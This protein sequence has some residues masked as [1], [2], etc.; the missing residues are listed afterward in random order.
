MAPDTEVCFHFPIR[1]LPS[2]LGLLCSVLCV[3]FSSTVPCFCCGIKVKKN[4]IQYFG[5]LH[6]LYIKYIITLLFL[7]S[8][9]QK[10]VMTSM[11]FA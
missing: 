1:L 4:I 2:I 11:T 3:G 9:L 6:R 8:F 7:M 10:Q 5:L